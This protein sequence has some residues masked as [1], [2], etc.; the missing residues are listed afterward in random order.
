MFRRVILYKDTFQMYPIFFK[1][2]RS[3]SNVSDLFL[4]VSDLFQIDPIDLPIDLIF[5]KSIRSFQITPRHSFFF[6]EK[7]K[8][9]SIN[10]FWTR[11]GQNSK[12][13]AGRPRSKLLAGSC[14]QHPRQNMLAA[15]AA[16]ATVPVRCTTLVETRKTKCHQLLLI[17]KIQQTRLNMQ[18]AMFLIYTR[19]CLS[20]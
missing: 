19:W 12:V 11:F 8:R 16:A 7:N 9:Q 13:C 3:F 6:S 18:S 10:N 2:I 5:F 4:N 20:S 17:N 15:A 14:Y 1:C